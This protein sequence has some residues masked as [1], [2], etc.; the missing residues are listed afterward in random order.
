MGLITLSLCLLFGQEIRLPEAISGGP[1]EFILVRPE[2]TGKIVRF[3]G[4]DSGLSVFPSGQ[5]ADQRATVVVAL[6]PGKYRLLCYTAQGDNPSPPAIVS[7]IVGNGPAPVPVDPLAESLRAIYGAIQEPGRA[8]TAAR[9][10]TVYRKFSQGFTANRLNDL[11]GQMKSETAGIKG[12]E[13]LRE[14]LADHLD[15]A[16]GTDGTATVGP[17][18]KAKIKAEFSKIAGILEGLK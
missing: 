16:L 5:L 4:L 8:D 10:A 18:L 9:L 11:F 6:L 15:I 12:C 1:G 14:R 2:T 7:I 3:V 13:T 17:E